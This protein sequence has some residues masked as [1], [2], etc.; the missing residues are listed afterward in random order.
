MKQWNKSDLQGM[1]VSERLDYYTE[2]EPNTGCWLWVGALSTGGYGKIYL[3]NKYIAA[4][5]ASWVVHHGPIPNGL[6]VCHKCD[7]KLCIN[8]EHLFLGTQKENIEDAT[9]KGRMSH[10][11]D[12]PT[13]KLKESQVVNIFSD[14]RTASKIAAQYNITE[15]AVYNIKAGRRWGYLGL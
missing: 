8:P 13:S 3:D 1:S 12:R 11:E 10:G 5:R 6:L 7:V 9:R 15:T 14:I 4:H 2:P